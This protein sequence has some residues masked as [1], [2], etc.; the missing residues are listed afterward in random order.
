MR[1]RHPK[2]VHLRNL[3]VAGYFSPNNA[4]TKRTHFDF[5]DQLYNAFHNQHAR[6]NNS[7]PV[8][9]DDPNSLVFDDLN[10]KS[11]REMFEDELQ[12]Q[13]MMG[14]MRARSNSEPNLLA[15]DNELEVEDNILLMNALSKSISRT[16]SNGSMMHDNEADGYRSHNSS[17]R[18]LSRYKNSCNS[19]RNNSFYRSSNIGT[20]TMIDEFAHFPPPAS[21]PPKA[22]IIDFQDFR[23]TMDAE[24]AENVHKLVPNGSPRFVSVDYVKPYLL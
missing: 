8:P 14:L 9:V 3:D 13:D 4:T 12:Q 1:Q 20:P 22:P 6:N 18:S 21:Q 10:I 5:S 23:F 24:I 19:S 17:H 15:V 2:R 11:N 7:A 16:A